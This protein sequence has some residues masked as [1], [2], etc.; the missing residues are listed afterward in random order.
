MRRSAA[1]QC[2]AFADEV[3]KFVTWKVASKK[4]RVTYLPPPPQTDRFAPEN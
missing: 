1:I 3:A 4:P 2:D